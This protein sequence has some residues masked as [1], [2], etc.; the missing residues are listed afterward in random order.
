MKEYEKKDNT[1]YEEW[2]DAQYKELGA[3]HWDDLKYHAHARRMVSLVPD[4]E[5]R[6]LDLGCG[7]GYIMSLLGKNTVGLDVSGEA[8]EIAK[9]K[10]GELG[11]D[12][13]E[14]VHG[15][16][17]KLPFK[18]AEFD[19]VVCSEVMEH[20]LE[21]DA[22]RMLDETERVL[23]PG[24][25]L[26]FSTPRVPDDIDVHFDIPYKYKHQSFSS[27]HVKEYTRDEAVKKVGRVLNVESDFAAGALGVMQKIKFVVTLPVT[28]TYIVARKKEVEHAE[29]K[30]LGL[31]K[32]SEVQLDDKTQPIAQTK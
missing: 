25:M 19:T 14:L 4:K 18:D 26:V 1:N 30:K 15:T 2:Y 10:L 5:A 24:G 32:V 23:K 20:L 8:L 21:S 16:A 9:R 27:S 17:T 6:I 28:K 12:G 29:K 13:V 22:E 11:R 7:E 3:Y 31:V